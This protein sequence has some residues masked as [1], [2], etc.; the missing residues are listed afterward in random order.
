MGRGFLDRGLVSQVTNKLANKKKTRNCMKL[1]ILVSFFI[2][3]T[4]LLGD[5]PLELLNS[6][7]WEKANH[8]TWGAS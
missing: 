8:W 2:R 3:T 6:Y 5:S 7:Q 4:Y 1:V